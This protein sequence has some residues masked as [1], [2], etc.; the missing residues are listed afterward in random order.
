M[1]RKSLNSKDRGEGG[2]G[3]SQINSREK[4][5]SKP[6]LLTNIG[7]LLTLPASGKSTGPRRGPELKDI[8]LIQDAAVL[9]VN[10]KIV[11]AGKRK[12]VPKFFSQQPGA[13]SQQLASTELDCG[14]R[15]V[16]P[17]FVDAHTHPVFASARL[18]DFEKRIAGASYEEIAAAGGGIRSSVDAVRKASGKEL[19]GYALRAFEAMA[20]C[21]TTTVEAKSG[22]GLSIEAELKSL[23]AIRDAA[24]KWPGTVV[25]TLLGAHV[26]PKEF[27]EKPKK[28]V[29]E[30]ARKMIPQAAKRG[31]AQFVDVF[32]ERSA[33]TM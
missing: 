21:G 13:S 6:L 29:A 5:Q 8:G 16:T 30:I 22:Y 19:A 28:Y 9:C 7:E 26:V 14:G 24:E 3:Y 17:G 20:A 27:R 18:V 4:S 31:L 10:G 33:F 15:V 23:E 11:S 32:I 12:D 1:P 25:A 2:R